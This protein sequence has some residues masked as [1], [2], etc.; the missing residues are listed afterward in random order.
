MHTFFEPR[1]PTIGRV[2][3]LCDI[4]DVMNYPIIKRE[5]YEHPNLLLRPIFY[6]KLTSQR[7]ASKGTKSCAHVHKIRSAEAYA[8]WRLE[9]HAAYQSKIRTMTKA[10]RVA[11]RI[12]RHYSPLTQK[13]TIPLYSFTPDMTSCANARE[14]Q[15][16]NASVISP[17]RADVIRK[18]FFE[19]AKD[20]SIGGK[21]GKSSDTS[22][23][24][25]LV[26]GV[27]N[28]ASPDIVTHT[29]AARLNELSYLFNLAKIE[30]DTNEEVQ[31]AL[32]K[33]LGKNKNQR[34]EALA[35]HC[36]TT[37]ISI[38]GDGEAESDIGAPHLMDLED[39]TFPAL[40]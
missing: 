16:K 34:A 12:L 30:R 29:K 32:R 22:Y 19:K 33:K 14:R 11:R 37:A 18:I 23:G 3:A 21:F 17:D 35:R 38:L 36:P 26:A 7:V 15:H 31:D 4:V 27:S 25:A 28:C 39:D 8:L 40:F 6:M 20:V 2:R 13:S 10:G 9:T 24:G 1:C 5:L